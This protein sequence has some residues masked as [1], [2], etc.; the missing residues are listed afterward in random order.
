M[1]KL[2]TILLSI[3][4]IFVLASSTSGDTIPELPE[5]TDKTK[6]GLMRERV[7]INVIADG[8]VKIINGSQINWLDQT[9]YQQTKIEFGKILIQKWHINPNRIHNIQIWIL[10]KG[11]Y[12]NPVTNEKQLGDVIVKIYIKSE[13]VS[14]LVH[15]MDFLI[16]VGDELRSELTGPWT[17]TNLR[18][19]P[20][21]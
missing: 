8:I 15:V 7:F 19:P 2:I 16:D 12:V 20:I 9:R 17:V 1:K 3:F 6:Q 5:L 10:K 18:G 11:Y 13:Y 14:G 4:L 21:I